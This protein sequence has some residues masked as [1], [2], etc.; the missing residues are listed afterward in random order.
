MKVIDALKTAIDKRDWDIVEKVLRAIESK[1]PRT[2]DRKPS[3]SNTF[4]DDGTLFRDQMQSVN[5]AYKSL[6]RSR[7]PR[8]RPVVY[9]ERNCTSCGNSVRMPAHLASN[10]SFVDSDASIKPLFKCEACIRG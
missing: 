8:R 9:V 3:N 2:V 7:T 10:Y 6:Y 1:Q 5:P 4:V